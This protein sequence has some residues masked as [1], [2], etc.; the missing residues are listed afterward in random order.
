MMYSDEIWHALVNRY[1]ALINMNTL[2]LSNKLRT[3]S[4]FG[5]RKAIKHTFSNQRWPNMICCLHT[6][7]QV[8]IVA[9]FILD[10]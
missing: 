7:N 1:F 8:K 9:S 5:L 2:L 6:N 3:V 10:L 4:G